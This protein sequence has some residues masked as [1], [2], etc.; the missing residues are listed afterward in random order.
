MQSSVGHWRVFAFILALAICANFTIQILQTDR[1]QLQPDRERHLEQSPTPSEFYTQSLDCGGI[2]IRAH[3]VVAYAALQIA[4]GEVHV[5]LRH[6][7]DVRAN[8]IAAGVEVH[9]VGRKQMLTDLP[10]F[11]GLKGKRDGDREFDKERGISGMTVVCPE[12]NL[13]RLPEDP[14]FALHSEAC[15]HEF[16]HAIQLEGIPKHLQDLVERRF[17][18][19]LQNHLWEDTYASTNVLEFFAETSTW[20]FVGAAGS[21][22]AKGWNGILPMYDLNG[23]M[24]YD[25]PTFTMLHDIY[26]GR[27]DIGKF[28]YTKAR[29]LAPQPVGRSSNCA[30]DGLLVF[31]NQ[32]ASPFKLYLVTPEGQTTPFGDIIPFQRKLVP[33]SVGC[34]WLLSDDGNQ[35]VNIFVP[36][37]LYS[38]ASIE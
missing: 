31:A 19:A 12:E 20:Y 33:S 30:P 18:W 16:A 21:F 37:S 8:L 1:N 22:P 15:V 11:T 25:P 26:E 36:Q 4:C 28:A 14:Y 13:L 34:R 29:R 23:L 35:P 2:S 17:K 10:E 32:T 27:L 9:V 6:I 38:Y 5:M 24:I 7:P 3:R